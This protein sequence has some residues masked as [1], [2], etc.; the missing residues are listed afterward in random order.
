[1]SMPLGWGAELVKLVLSI[2]AHQDKTSLGQRLDY[3]RK[4]KRMFIATTNAVSCSREYSLV[5]ACIL[6]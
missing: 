4:D 6:T 3:P 1:M 5:V 2:T